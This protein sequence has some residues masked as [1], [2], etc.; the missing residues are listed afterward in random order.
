[1]DMHEYSEMP[2]LTTATVVLFP[3]WE[4][5]RLMKDSF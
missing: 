3:A 1:M 4:M 5:V 2:F